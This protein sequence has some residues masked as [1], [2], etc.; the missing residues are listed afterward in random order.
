MWSLTH[1]FRYIYCEFEEYGY[2]HPQHNYSVKEKIIVILFVILDGKNCIENKS[3]NLQCNK[4]SK[5]NAL[6]EPFKKKNLRSIQNVTN[7]ITPE[8]NNIST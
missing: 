6:T 7:T 3:L 8:D 4:L 1:I 2:L 5:N